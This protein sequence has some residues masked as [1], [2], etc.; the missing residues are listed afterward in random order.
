MQFFAEKDI[1]NQES[2]SL[3][4]GIRNYR[5][6]IEEHKEYIKNPQKYISDW[7]EKTEYEKAGLIKHWNKEIRNFEIS[8]S[9]RIEELKKRGDFNE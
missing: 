8:I 7:N 6:R 1:Q 3:N 4:R 9:D 2:V 5:K